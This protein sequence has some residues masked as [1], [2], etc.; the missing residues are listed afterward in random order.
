M[1]TPKKQN[2]SQKNQ[3]V[4]I[5]EQRA[6]PYTEPLLFEYVLGALTSPL[7]IFIHPSRASSRGDHTPAHVVQ[8][9]KAITEKHTASL[10]VLRRWRYVK[11]FT[12][13]RSW[14]GILKLRPNS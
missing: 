11:S 8:T 9:R 3:A 1:H 13:P 14:F 2:H 10:G 12:G 6:R 5:A 7:V 4:G